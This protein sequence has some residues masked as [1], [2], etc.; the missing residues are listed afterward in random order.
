MP[1]IGEVGALSHGLYWRVLPR[2]VG[3]SLAGKVS[4]HGVQES[5]QSTPKSGLWTEKK[6]HIQR[7][8]TA[9]TFQMSVRA[10]VKNKIYPNFKRH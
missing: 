1:N 4:E 2:G 9:T 3:V 10:T 8:Y 7:V 6:Q 5:L